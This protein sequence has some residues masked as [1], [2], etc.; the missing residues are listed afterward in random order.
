MQ[1]YPHQYVCDAEG[2]PSGSVSVS[3]VGPTGIDTESPAEFGG[4]GGTWSPETLL[5]AAVADCFVLTFRA[6]AKGA[7]LDWKGLRCTVDGTLQRAEGVTR[8]THFATHARLTVPS[9][10][11]V[12]A[13]RALLEKA[14]QKCLVANSLNAARSLEAEV[15][16]AG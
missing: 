8:F 4:P 9:G 14:E 13:A 3:T 10:A 6:L 11:D 7:K 2:G 16:S 5:S 12:A 1:P 15:V